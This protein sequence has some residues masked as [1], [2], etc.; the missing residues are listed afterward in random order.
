MGNASAGDVDEEGDVGQRQ[1][2]SSQFLDDLSDLVSG[3]GLG[4]LRVSH[5]LPGCDHAGHHAIADI[6][7]GGDVDV[8]RETD[9][10]NEVPSSPFEAL[11][12]GGS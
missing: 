5:G 2:K 6:G 9:L 11:K 12:R 3:R 1:A 4:L 10:L 7:A 8:G